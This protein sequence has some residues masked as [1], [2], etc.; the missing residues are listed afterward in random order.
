[1]M[2]QKIHA[3]DSMGIN[4][5]NTIYGTAIIVRFRSKSCAVYAISHF[6]RKETVRFYTVYLL[7]FTQQI[8]H[9]ECEF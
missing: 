4:D 3:S 9:F 8:S 1:M 7:P 6:C 2:R 5:G